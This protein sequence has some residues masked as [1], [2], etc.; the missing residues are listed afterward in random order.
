MDAL[1][2]LLLT[3]TAAWLFTTVIKFVCA[4]VLTR[5][6]KPSERASILVAVGE[7]F[8]VGRRTA[9]RG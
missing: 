5:D 1:W 2:Y 8:R 6:A 9:A 3:P 7:C 4:L